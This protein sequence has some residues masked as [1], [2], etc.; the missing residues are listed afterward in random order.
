M[1]INCVLK[2]TGVKLYYI[3]ENKWINVLNERKLQK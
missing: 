2:G 1:A 3:I